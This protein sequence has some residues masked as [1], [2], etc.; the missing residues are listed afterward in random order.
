[1]IFE[2]C[3]MLHA[4]WVGFVLWVTNCFSFS[5]IPELWKRVKILLPLHFKLMYSFYFAFVGVFKCFD[6]WN[7]VFYVIFK[8]CFNLDEH[9]EASLHVLV[10]QYCSYLKL[11]SINCFCLAESASWPDVTKGT[12]KSLECLM[13]RSVNCFFFLDIPKEVK[14][15]FMDWLRLHGKSRVSNYM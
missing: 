2:V 6:E 15:Q 5:K 1:M 12:D 10:N 9:W 13:L 11:R 3:L 14:S 7:N 8:P 4:I